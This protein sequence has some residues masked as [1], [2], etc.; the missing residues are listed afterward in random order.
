[1]SDLIPTSK[2]QQLAYQAMGLQPVDPSLSS[3]ER[4]AMREHI[5][6]TCLEMPQWAWLR[7]GTELNAL[8]YSDDK[9]FIHS[10]IWSPE[11]KAR[12]WIQYLKKRFQADRD[13]EKS[14]CDKTATAWMQWAVLQ[15][16]LAKVNE[17]R[18]ER[19]LL[20]LPLPSS[21]SQLRPYQSMMRRVDDWVEPDV[22]VPGAQPNAFEMDAPY[23]ADQSEVI[24]AWQEAWESIPPEKRYRQGE[25]CPPTQAQSS[26]Y[27][28]RKQGLL[29][30]KAREEREKQEALTIG[31]LPAKPDPQPLPSDTPQNGKPNPNPKPRQKTREEIEAENRQFQLEQDVQEYRHKLNNLQQD[32]ESLEAFIRNTLAREGTEAYLQKM[33]A[34]NRGIFSVND[35]I[36][37]LRNAVMVCQSIYKLI[38]EPYVAPQPISR[39]E[40]DPSTAT[41]DL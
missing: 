36:D 31:Q 41:I 37:K 29:Q 35:D 8:K 11:D 2:T 9:E 24:A 32:A 34:L 15:P 17:E 10:S 38:T 5:I 21:V 16:C 1:M 26:D 14:I 6:D 28:R 3:A 13:P 4:C 18:A 39:R 12:G 7:A 27:L 19:G 40:V 30:L 23:A 33:R 20:P 25:P 22:N